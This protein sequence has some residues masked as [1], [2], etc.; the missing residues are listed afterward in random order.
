V[1]LRLAA[2]PSLC[3]GGGAVFVVAL[4]VGG[5]VVYGVALLGRLAGRPSP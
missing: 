5:N 2:A 4:V 1:S 3:G